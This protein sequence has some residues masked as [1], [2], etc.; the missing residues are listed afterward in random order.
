M[1]HYHI[2]YPGSRGFI[3]K[4]V[5]TFQHDIKKLEKQNSIFDSPIKWWRIWKM[6]VKNI[7]KDPLR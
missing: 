1:Y 5:I 6:V 2:S 4:Y 3:K 7:R